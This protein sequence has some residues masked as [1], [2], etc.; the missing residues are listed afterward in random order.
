M[1]FHENSF[2]MVTTKFSFMSIE[3]LRILC[4]AFVKGVESERLKENSR[5]SQ[6]LFSW[7]PQIDPPR[8][9]DF[10]IPCQLS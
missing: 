2:S 7:L 6:V 3:F 9:I 1:T 10:D 8:L 4:D 5:K